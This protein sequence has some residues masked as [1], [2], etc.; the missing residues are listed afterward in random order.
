MRRRV[1]KFSIQ[2]LGFL[3]ILLGIAGIILP[4]L[5][6]IFFLALGIILLSLYSPKAKE[7]LKKASGLH[8]KAAYVITRA[9]RVVVKFVGDIEEDLKM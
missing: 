2:M 1:K 8:P 3:L 4:V 9:E 7:L 6:G 5:N